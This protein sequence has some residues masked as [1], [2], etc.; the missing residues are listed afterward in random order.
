MMAA[1]IAAIAHIPAGLGALE[2][3]FIALLGDRL[4]Q[5]QLLAA[6]LVY[7]AVYYIVPLLLALIVYFG[8][9]ARTPARTRS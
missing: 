4:A 8:L 1:I 3:T 5:P 9:E 7:R 2:A 6:L